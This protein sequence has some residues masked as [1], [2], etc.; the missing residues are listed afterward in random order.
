MKKMLKILTIVVIFWVFSLKVCADG[1]VDEYIDDF[2]EILPG[3]VSSDAEE[4]LD[5][6]G[7]DALIGEIYNILSGNAS[8]A[9]GILLI[10]VSFGIFS[11]LI[12]SAPIKNKGVC[13]SALGA[14]LSLS[15]LPQIVP[16]FTSARDAVSSLVDFFSSAVPIFTAITVA[17]GAVSTAS[18]QAV[19]MNFTLSLLSGSFISLMIGAVTLSLAAAVLSFFDDGIFSGL[20]RAIFGF[21]KWIVGIGAALIM[22]TLSLQSVV[23]S[24]SDSAAMR[25][26][27][28]AASGMIPI[29]GNT[30]SAALSTLASGLSYARGVVGVGAIAAVLSITLSP[31]VL[32]LIVR[33]AFSLGGEVCS[34]FGTR[35]RVSA[36]YRSALDALIAVYALALC[37]VIFE[38][39]LF[40]K[41][42]V[43]LV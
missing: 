40:M 14:I 21:F 36:A 19:G 12:E 10:I 24:A 17:G 6:V 38:I 37:V 3:G 13:R 7:I 42:G 43:S 20:S 34:L 22:G 23:A 41:S 9:V 1:Y 35:E 32:M 8:R 5:G 30:V 15:L 26:A 28:Y 11:S 2:T 27:K 4:L 16:I 18:V 39:I 29:V 33:S 31:L 25:A